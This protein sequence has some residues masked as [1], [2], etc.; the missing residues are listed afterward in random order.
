[1]PLP[2]P[3]YIN[4][5]WTLDLT[6]GSTGAQQVASCGG[7]ITKA[8]IPDIEV[9]FDTTK[10][11]ALP[12]EI[13]VPVSTK[14]ME[15]SISFMRTSTSLEAAL[16]KAMMRPVIAVLSCTSYSTIDITDTK[17]LIYTM[18]GFGKTFQGVE[19]KAQEA[20]E[21][22]VTIAVNRFQKQFGTKLMSYDPANWNWFD[23]AT[24][25]LSD[26][27]TGLNI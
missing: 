3:I 8:K 12:G 11:A 7:L 10:M 16:D 2:S 6:I 1:M 9:E 14:A 21:A 25:L 4:S 24:N 27:K 13:H 22:E 18:T 23:G 20:S 19:F 26:L 15:M 5:H 17:S